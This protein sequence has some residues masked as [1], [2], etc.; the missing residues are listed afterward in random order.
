MQLD[1]YFLKFEYLDYEN[2]KPFK[3]FH[4]FNLLN[5]A[6][7]PF[8][9]QHMSEIFKLNFSELLSIYNLTTRQI[10]KFSKID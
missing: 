4:V 3:M 5:H 10:S 8:K 7:N 6:P 1:T 9:M 2:V